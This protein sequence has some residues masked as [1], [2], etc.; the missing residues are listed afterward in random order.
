MKKRYIFSII[1]VVLSLSL[2][3]LYN[4]EYN[5]KTNKVIKSSEDDMTMGD[6]EEIF[7]K[8]LDENNI[9][10]KFGTTE[11]LDYI[12]TQMLEPEN[13]DKKLEKH[14]QYKLIGIYFS[15]YIVATQNEE[16]NNPLSL[17]RFK[18]RTIAQIRNMNIV[19][20]TQKK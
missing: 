8:Y 19:N 15:E 1:L 17:S 18:N 6:I 4:N 20:D 3:Y 14:P 12:T 7:Q 16:L 9:N 5:N 2:F 13:I 10:I 11:Y